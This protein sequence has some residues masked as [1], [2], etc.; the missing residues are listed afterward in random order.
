MAMSLGIG[1]GLPFGGAAAAV[2]LGYTMLRDFDAIT[3]NALTATT[4]SAATLSIDTSDRHVQGTGGF[5]LVGNGSNT[6]QSISNCKT[7]TDDMAAWDTLAMCIDLGEGYE[8]T[9]GDLRLRFVSSATNYDYRAAPSTSLSFPYRTE[10]RGKVWVSFKVR[11]F[12]VTDFAGASVQSLGT[13]SKTFN[14]PTINANPNAA[15][16]IVID[17]AVI[18]ATSHKP[19][20]CITFDDSVATQYSAAF[21]E[22]QARGLVGTLYVNSGL[23]GTGGYL[24]WAQV[25]EMYLAGWGICLNSERTDLPITAPATRTAAITALQ[26]V[27]SDILAGMLGVGTDLTGYDGLNHFAYSYGSVG[28][29]TGVVTQSCNPN[30]TT[31]LTVSN[32]YGNPIC[33]G[34][35]I[36]GTGVPA[37][38]YVVRTLSNTSIETSAAIATGTGVSLTF[39]GRISGLTRTNASDSTV[40]T[41]SSTTNVFA[42][43]HIYGYNIPTDTRVVSVDSATQ[44]TVDQTVTA[45]TAV[46]CNFGYIDGEFW[47]SKVQDDLIAAGFKSGRRVGA[48]GYGGLFTGWGI[49]PLMAVGVPGIGLTDPPSAA[50]TARISTW[51]EEK[52]DIITYTHNVTNLAGFET[53]L[54]QVVTWR[55]AGLVEVRTIPDW[56]ATVTARPGIDG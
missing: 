32:A 41:I 3:Q 4:T 33:A 16:D 44:V 46:R 55:D 5:R 43:M 29:P 50:E 39:T 11:D 42:G 6:S 47:P 54:D 37:G 35:R 22:M 9:I 8:N 19:I 15:T 56:W 1:I 10:T 34:M 40:L 28:Y 48:S 12:K 38:C 26:T 13:A 31:T 52:T 2:P 20:L 27:R 7:F 14:I 24:T 18:P 25:E 23:I 51:I 53:F 36:A 49:D 45:G 17:A 30:N 21:P